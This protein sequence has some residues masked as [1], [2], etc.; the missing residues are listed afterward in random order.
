MRVA[1][2]GQAFF[3]AFPRRI[4]D[5]LLPHDIN[6]EQDYEIAVSVSLGDEDFKNFITDM[7]ADR[8]F[9]EDYYDRCAEGEVWKCL[10]V[11]QQG[12]RDGI[13]LIPK[14]RCHVKYAA[15]YPGV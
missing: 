13:L 4:G 3:V 14:D 1:R 5:L 12:K 8:Q 10:L 15:Y 2:S 9:I 7:V 6:L 11:R